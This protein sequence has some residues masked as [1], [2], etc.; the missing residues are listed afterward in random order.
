MLTI[1]LDSRARQFS[2]LAEP[3]R[4]EI[5]E[6]LAEGASSVAEIARKMPVTRPAVS[7]HLKVLLEAGLVRQRV[8]GTRHLY[9]IDPAGVGE[10]RDYLDSMWREALDSFKQEAE[11]AY[12]ESR[13]Q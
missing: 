9:R 7:Q 2:A 8:A 3:R 6:A 4:R 1:T 13:E 11:R 5:L 10:V 12:R